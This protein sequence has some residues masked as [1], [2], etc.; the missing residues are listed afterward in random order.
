[1]K[2]FYGNEQMNKIIALLIASLLS[3]SSVVLAESDKVGVKI[4]VVNVAL[5]LEKSPQ[6]ESATESLKKEF[7]VQQNDLK[8]RALTLDKEQQDYELNKAV[9]SETQ[10]MAKEREFTLKSREIQR[11]RNDIQDMINLRRNEELAKLQELVNQAIK[12]VADQNKFDLILYEGIAYTNGRVDITEDVLKL[13]EVLNNDK[14]S[15]FNQ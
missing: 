6:A 3:F 8:N 11:T 1:V 9:M 4:G 14:V 5:L 2:Y 13:L 10:R 7:S 12:K 15:S